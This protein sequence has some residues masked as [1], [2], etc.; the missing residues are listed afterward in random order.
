MGDWTIRPIVDDEVLDWFALTARVFHQHRPL[1]ADEKGWLLERCRGQQV[2]GAFDGDR[3]VATFRTWA[4]DLPVPG[5]TVRAQ[6]VSSVTVAPTHRR[7]GLLTAMMRR[8][9]EEGR[10]DGL[11]VSVLLA[12][13]GSIYERFGYGLAAEK[14]DWRLDATRA[15]FRDPSALAECE[16]RL[17][18]DA[19]LLDVAPAIQSQAVARLPGDVPRDRPMWQLQLGLTGTVLD[20]KTHPHSAVILSRGGAP[21]GY[22]RYR[23][24]ER[25]QRGDPAYVLK[26][27]DLATVD[28]RAY[29]AIWQFFAS[30]DLVTVIVAPGL[31]LTDPLQWL[32]VDPRAARQRERSDLTWLR[33]LDATKSLTARTYA[34]SGSWVLGIDDSER[35]RLT[36][37]N[38]RG[39]AMPTGGEPDVRLSLHAL[40]SAYLGQVSFVTLHA[41]GLVTEQRPGA[42][43]ELATAFAHV[44]GIVPTSTGY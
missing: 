14:C 8:G 12:S 23:V 32:L 21:V 41:A 1:T 10:V 20:D 4:C 16:V 35:L 34:T 30:I 18:T 26:V 29:A 24:K 27:E 25:W 15:R 38:G 42:I 44:P 6:A 36:V 19:D 11:V 2:T 33:I 31:P 5:G 17:C 43:R 13:E 39:S 22:A 40:G 28:A 37:E 9:L 7:R 3:L